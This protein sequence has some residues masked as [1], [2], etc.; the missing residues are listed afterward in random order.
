M[1][2]QSTCVHDKEEK[3]SIKKK[4]LLDIK[5]ILESFCL[6]IQNLS[7]AIKHKINYRFFILEGKSVK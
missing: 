2:A 5:N 1:Y 3:E 7:L 6:E 4:N